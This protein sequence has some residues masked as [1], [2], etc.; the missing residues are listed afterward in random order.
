MIFA[1]AHR[2]KEL[3]GKAIRSLCGAIRDGGFLIVGH[4]DRYASIFMR[5][6]DRIIHRHCHGLDTLLRADILKPSELARHKPRGHGVSYTAA[7]RRGGRSQL[8]QDRSKALNG[9]LRQRT[10]TALKIALAT[11]GPSTGTE[12]SPM[13][14]HQPSLESSRCVT[15]SGISP[16]RSGG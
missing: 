4:G 3:R 10:P 16:K 15:T 11:A 13:P 6:G 5:F 8:D 2:G 14:P 7:L 12:A 9:V 1:L